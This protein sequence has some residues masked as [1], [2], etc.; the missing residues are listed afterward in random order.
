M[1]AKDAPYR[2]M[3]GRPF[4]LF[5][6]ASLWQGEDHLLFVET[7]LFREQHKRFYFNDIQSIVLQRTGTHLVLSSVWTALALLFFTLALAA[8]GPVYVTGTLA[9]IFGSALLVNIIKGP[10]CMVYLQTAVQIQKI[11]CLKRVRTAGK[12]L[13]RIKTLVEE[14][15]GTWQR[16][17]SGAARQNAPPVGVNTSVAVVMRPHEAQPK[18]RY[19]SLLHRILFSVLLAMGVL[20]TVQL[21]LK[22]LPIGFLEALLHAAALILSIVALARWFRHIKGS[23]IA[24]INWMAFFFI[25]LVTGVGYVLFF[26]V[27]LRNPELNYHHWAMFK[28]MFE[29]QA[30]DHPLALTGNI[31]Y[32]GGCLLVGALGLLAIRREPVLGKPSGP[33]SADKTPPGQTP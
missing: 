28:L 32:A 10:T 21:F 20:G 2:R 14:R 26:V 17:Q 24:K 1:A 8:S 12:A 33:S 30:T 19:K 29:L 23:L 22:S 13:T 5:T 25:C 27:T 7:V 6:T 18:G 31:I 15:Q 9:V 16:Q 3:P 4:A 11:S